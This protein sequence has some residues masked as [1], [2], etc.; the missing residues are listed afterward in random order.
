MI[1]GQPRELELVRQRPEQ[2]NTVQVYPAETWSQVL[3]KIGIN[4]PN[5]WVAQKPGA[6]ENF[7]PGDEVYPYLNPS[8]I[9]KVH[10]NLRSDVGAKRGWLMATLASLIE[11]LFPK[12]ASKYSPK[13]LAIPTTVQRDHNIRTYL[14]DWGWKKTRRADGIVLYEGYYYAGGNSWA[15]QVIEKGSNLFF[16]ILSPPMDRISQSPWRN[17][18]HSQT[19]DGWYGVGFSIEPKDAA[20]G[21]AAITNI[22]QILYTKPEYL[23]RK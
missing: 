9:T 7:K 13:G 3:E 16:K 23:W 19:K 21:V 11:S 15:G 2:R 10:I 1:K 14:Q 22:L 17:C 4:N 20:S 6:E 18:F 8:T 12:P 5:D